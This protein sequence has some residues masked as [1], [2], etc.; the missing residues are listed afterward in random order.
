MPRK[1]E[2]WFSPSLVMGWHKNQP[3]AQRRTLALK[4]HRG[5]KLA[6][7]RALQQLANITKDKDTKRLARIDAVYF[8]ALYY[9]ERKK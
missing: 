4:S 5:D 1:S 9:K 6:T 3:S 2:K 8:Y 7:A